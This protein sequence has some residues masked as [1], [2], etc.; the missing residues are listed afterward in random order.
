MSGVFKS[1][2]PMPTYTQ[3]WDVDI[4]LKYLISLVFC[5]N[6]DLK[7]LTL[8]VASLKLYRQ[9]A[10]YQNCT[11]MQIYPKEIEYKI[12][13]LTKTRRIGQEP[14]KLIFS[15]IENEMLDVGNT[16]YNI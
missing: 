13:H 7:K 12:V 1:R 6:L 10:S 3:T 16:F 9:L 5:E 2:P 15:K 8:K 4:V 11:H 14:V